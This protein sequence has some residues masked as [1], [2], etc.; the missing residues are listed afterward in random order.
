MMC[1]RLLA[2]ERAKAKQDDQEHQARRQQQWA[3][4]NDSTKGQARLRRHRKLR[5]AANAAAQGPSE[6]QV[7]GEPAPMLKL[8]SSRRRRMRHDEGFTT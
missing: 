8:S 6:D 3:K 2:A 7:G 4:Y 5:Q 1:S